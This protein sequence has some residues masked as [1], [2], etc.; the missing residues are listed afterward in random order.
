MRPRARPPSVSP[1]PSRTIAEPKPVAF[2]KPSSSSRHVTGPT[3]SIRVPEFFHRLRVLAKRRGVE[4]KKPRL[5]SKRAW[6]LEAYLHPHLQ[7]DLL[8]NSRC[9]LSRL[10]RAD[11]SARAVGSAPCGADPTLPHKVCVIPTGAAFFLPR[12]GGINA[13]R[14]ILLGPHQANR[15]ALIPP[16]RSLTLAPVGMTQKDRSHKCRNSRRARTSPRARAKWKTPPPIKLCAPFPRS[17]Q[18]GQRLLIS[19][20]PAFSCGRG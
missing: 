19:P 10:A 13:Q 1:T 14:F 9:G 4:P 7:R 16:L 11:Q 6:L 5:R 12:S 18:S 15:C 3:R 8:R 2:A 20:S 17:V